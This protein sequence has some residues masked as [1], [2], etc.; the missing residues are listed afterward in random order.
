MTTAG[1]QV[2]ALGGTIDKVYFDA[3]SEYQVGEPQAGNIF[4]DAGLHQTI[5]I[6]SICRKDSL[7]IDDT[8]RTALLENIKNLSAHKILVT[9]GTDTMTQSAQLVKR[10][11]VHF[12]DK[13]IVFVGAM[14][15][16]CFKHSDAPFNLGFAMGALQALLPGV[17][18]TMSGQIFDP[19]QVEKN[20]EARQFQSSTLDN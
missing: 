11:H 5:K 9:H 10:N 6:T 4:Q 14:S 13:V 8:D 2:L 17:Y 7:D 3:L 18:I 20:R 1:I 12:K 16:A 19:D 15:P